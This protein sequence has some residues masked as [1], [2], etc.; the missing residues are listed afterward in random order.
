MYS[1]VRF[2]DNCFSNLFTAS[3]PPELRYSCQMYWLNIYQSLPWIWLFSYIVTSYES[4][5]K[6]FMN[7]KYDLT[8]WYHKIVVPINISQILCQQNLCWL[9][10]RRKNR[11][12]I[13]KWH[14]L[15]SQGFLHRELF[16]W[17]EKPFIIGIT[18]MKWHHFRRFWH[19]KYE[20]IFNWTSIWRQ[21]L[22]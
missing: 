6:N 11:C 14:Q 12:H 13:I 4:I 18:V 21:W 10:E 1:E 2:S 17:C 20:N 22:L 8:S 16:S 15:A 19:R 3:V 9:K 7:K 5:V